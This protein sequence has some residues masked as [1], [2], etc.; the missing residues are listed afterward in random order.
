MKTKNNTLIAQ[1]NDNLR[2]NPGCPG[3][4]M[5]RGVTKLGLEKINLVLEK[6]K[7]FDNFNED[8]DPYGEHDYGSVEHDGLTIMWKIEYYD[9]SLKCSSDDPSDPKKC[10][11]II[12]LML[13][14]EY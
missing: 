14:E 11:R 7:N 2:K 4:M 1:L 8:N 6:I 9:M 5:T 12:T 10:R 3:W 13:S